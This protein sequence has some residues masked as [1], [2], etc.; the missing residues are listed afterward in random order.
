M[1]MSSHHC[2]F[3]TVL[4]ALEAACVPVVRH[5]SLDA[6][7]Y[8]DKE[9]WAIFADINRNTGNGS[10][11]TG[12]ETWAS[13]PEVFGDGQKTPVWPAPGHRPKHLERLHQLEAF[14]QQGEA[15]RKQVAAQLDQVNSEV[16]L[17]L[18]TFQF[19]VDNGYWRFDGLRDAAAKRRTINLPLESIAVKAVWKKI[20]A[21]DRSFYHVQAVS[22]E[23]LLGLVA[24]HITSKELP[25]W[26]WATWENVHNQP[27]TYGPDRCQIHGCKDSFGLSSDGNS[28][29][30]ELRDLFHRYGLGDEWL[31][32]RLTGSQIDFITSTG[33]PT[34]LGNSQLESSIMDKSS[35]ITCHSRAA[36]DD[37]GGFLAKFQAEV[38]SPQPLWFE[39]DKHHHIQT[40]FLWSFSR[41]VDQSL[42]SSQK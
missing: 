33:D 12:W 18:P 28:V 27:V 15:F 40:D 6:A 2:L 37:R 29:T 19:I 35:C 14:A 24:L 7:S 13:A 10:P 23:S 42:R 30:P 41:T 4:A 5:P 11:D 34:F 21:A 1:R 9:A 38:G 31:N 26:L 32:Y 17:N 36:V 16:H 25:N 8:P 3:L 20:R 22:G 39:L